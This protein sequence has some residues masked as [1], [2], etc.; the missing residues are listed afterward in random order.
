MMERAMKTDMK[1]LN[2]KKVSLLA[3]IEKL[4][5]EVSKIDREIEAVVLAAHP[6]KVG[7]I[8]DYHGTPAKIVRVSAFSDGEVL[9]MVRKKLPSGGWSKRESI[10]MNWSNFGG[11]RQE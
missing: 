11:V 2:Y 4:K 1:Q 10:L 6:Q 5:D 3:D 7:D 9:T 8:V